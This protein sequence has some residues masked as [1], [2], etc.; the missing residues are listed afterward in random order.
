MLQKYNLMRYFMIQTF[1]IQL[2][3]CEKILL[4]VLL[5]IFI[6]GKRDYHCKIRCKDVIMTAMSIQFV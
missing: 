5:Y 4:H 1:L 2:S 3:V 6:F